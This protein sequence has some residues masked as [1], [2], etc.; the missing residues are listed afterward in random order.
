MRIVRG[1]LLRDITGSLCI[2]HS[3]DYRIHTKPVGRIPGE[4]SLGMAQNET[5]GIALSSDDMAV[6]RRAVDSSL[7][8]SQA[9]H[10]ETEHGREK[11]IKTIAG[12]RVMR[13]GT[14]C[15]VVKRIYFGKKKRKRKSYWPKTPEARA[16]VNARTKER[17][18]QN[19]PSPFLN[20]R[21]SKDGDTYIPSLRE[22]KLLESIRSRLSQ[23]LE[24]A[25]GELSRPK[26]VVSMVSSGSEASRPFHRQAG[27]C[28]QCSTHGGAKVEVIT[29]DEAAGTDYQQGD[30]FVYNARQL[31]RMP[32]GDWNRGLFF[33]ANG[34]PL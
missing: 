21:L 8:V 13:D 4:H 9:K 24:I 34:N 2:R 3:Y 19:L 16:K 33:T 6:L 31:H 26:A 32:H 30:V 17:R 5:F 28:I 14:T 1:A 20:G 29:S 12:K 22:K 25:P 11:A 15:N 7:R 23:H 10:V 18:Q 27:L